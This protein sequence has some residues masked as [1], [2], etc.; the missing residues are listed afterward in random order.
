VR[1][2]GERVIVGRVVK[3]G[4]AEKSRL[5]HEGDEILEVNG[6]DLR[7]KSVSEVCDMLVKRHTKAADAHLTC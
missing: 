2:D 4:I 3:G 5:L 7:G 1:N 6:V